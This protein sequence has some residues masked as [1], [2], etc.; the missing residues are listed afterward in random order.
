MNDFIESE[1]LPPNYNSYVRLGYHLV[2]YNING[3]E[4]IQCVEMST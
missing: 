2:V 3:V 1:K 4:K